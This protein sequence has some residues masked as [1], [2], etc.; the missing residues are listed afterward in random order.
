MNARGFSAFAAMRVFILLWIILLV[1]SP[2]VAK[3]E[4]ASASRLFEAVTSPLAR[5]PSASV[6]DRQVT[7][8]RQILVNQQLFM[9]LESAASRASTSR[10]ALIL[11]L[12]DD[13][14]EICLAIDQG[15]HRQ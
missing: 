10:Q 2:F 11:N 12:F 6:K 9:P 5:S 3:A 13:F 1:T 4:N 7:R 14:H 15:L 8:S